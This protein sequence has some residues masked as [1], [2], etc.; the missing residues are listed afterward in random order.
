VETGGERGP[1]LSSQKG[2]LT[3]EKEIPDG[4][5]KARGLGIIPEWV[6]RGGCSPV[7]KETQKVLS[8]N[9]KKRR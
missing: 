9:R 8:V 5:R 3:G 1:S 7:K 4:G 2:G 6:K